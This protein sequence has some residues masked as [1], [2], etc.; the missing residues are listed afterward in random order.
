MSQKAVHLF[1]IIIF[2]ALVGCSKATEEQV[3]TNDNE[4]DA[5]NYFYENSEWGIYI[6]T[7]DGWQIEKETAKNVQFNSEKLV[8]IISV[9]PKAY[10]VSEIKKQLLAGAGE[11]TVIGEG[12]NF[13]S[14]KTNRQGKH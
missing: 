2:L 14:W 11:V 12:L 1:L 3:N 6:E 5:S 4:Q 7:A 10:R 13:I 9:I 8:A